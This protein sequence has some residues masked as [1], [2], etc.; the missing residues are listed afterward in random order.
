MN[1]DKRGSEK[2]RIQYT[3]QFFLSIIVLIRVYL[4]SSAADISYL[5]FAKLRLVDGHNLAS[6]LQEH[7]I[8]P[9]TF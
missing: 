3:V 7:C 4:R 1:A 9:D 5:V 8:A 2:I 6:T